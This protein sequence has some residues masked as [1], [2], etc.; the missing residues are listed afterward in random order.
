MAFSGTFLGA[1]PYMYDEVACGKTMPPRIS[2]KA[3][4]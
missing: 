1:S 2:I 4:E 3:A